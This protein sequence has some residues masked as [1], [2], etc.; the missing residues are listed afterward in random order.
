MRDRLRSLLEWIAPRHLLSSPWTSTPNS[1]TKHLSSFGNDSFFRYLDSP[2]SQ[3]FGGVWRS[4]PFDSRIAD[5][6]SAYLTLNFHHTFVAARKHQNLDWYIGLGQCFTTVCLASLLFSALMVLVK[7]SVMLP[8]SSP[9]TIVSSILW[10][11]GSSVFCNSQVSSSL[12]D[13][14]SSTDL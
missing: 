12:G 9:T 4:E 13:G 3:L 10:S 2:L 1:S 5:L 8:Q 14:S 6:C 7:S 11:S